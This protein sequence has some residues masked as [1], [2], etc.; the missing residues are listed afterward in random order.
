MRSCRC[1]RVAEPLGGVVRRRGAV[2]QSGP[3]ARPRPGGEQDRGG[4][5]GRD[6]LNRRFEICSNGIVASGF[7]PVVVLAASA[8]STAALVYV[9]CRTYWTVPCSVVPARTEV[10]SSSGR[11]TGAYSSLSSRLWKAPAEVVT[12][13]RRSVF[14]SSGPAWASDT[15]SFQHDV[16]PCRSPSLPWLPG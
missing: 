13:I 12:P 9:V 4:H 15:S 2:R 7:V 16:R 6:A 5:P 11:R 14:D 1:L 3:A 10:Q 8:I